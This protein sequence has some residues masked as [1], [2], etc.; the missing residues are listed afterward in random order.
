[1]KVLK[2]IS[3][4]VRSLELKFDLNVACFNYFI[5]MI[6]FLKFLLRLLLFER[7]FLSHVIFVY[8]DLI[9]Q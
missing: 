5:F 1:M 8:I 9:C 3:I 6:K 2:L 4:P 7:F